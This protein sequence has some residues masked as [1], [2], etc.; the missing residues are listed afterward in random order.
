MLT[1]TEGNTRL[2]VWARI[3]RSAGVLR[4]W[5]AGRETLKNLGG[6][7]RSCPWKT[8][9]YGIQLVRHRRGNPDTDQCWH[10]RIDA[11]QVSGR[12]RRTGNR[13]ARRM[14]MGSRIERSTLRWGKLTTWGRSRRKHV[15]RKGHSSRTCRTGIR[16]ANLPAGF[17]KQGYTLHGSECNRGTGC[18]KT[19]RPGLY[20]GRRVTGVP[21]VAV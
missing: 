20:G 5:H 21:T 12:R 4:P 2:S 18:G 1:H 10:L 19:A 16:G 13:N 6:P 15:A 17:S 9:M 14:R 3:E 7:T 11:D 8:T